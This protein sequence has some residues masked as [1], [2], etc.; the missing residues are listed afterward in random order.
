MRARPAAA[1]RRS[2]SR[3]CRETDP[4][5]TPFNAATEIRLV[6]VTVQLSLI[7]HTEPRPFGAPPRPSVNAVRRSAE[8]R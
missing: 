2:G 4:N 3:R 5:A 8:S 7:E 1:S 6:V